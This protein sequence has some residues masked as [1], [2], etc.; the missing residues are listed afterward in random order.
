[1]EQLLKMGPVTLALRDFPIFTQYP[2]RDWKLDAFTVTEGTP[3]LVVCY[4]NAPIAATGEPVYR[5]HSV[6][7]HRQLYALPDGQL[8]WQQIYR[9]TLQLQMVVSRDRTVITVTADETQTC[10]MAVLE[11]LTFLVFYLFLQKQV[12]SFHGVLLEADGKGLVIAADSGVG[13][14]THARLWRDHKNALILN[15]DRSC[16]YS[17][18]GNWLGFGTPWCGTSGEYLNR[19]VPV[20]A[21]VVLER[22][23]VNQVTQL[24][25][26]QK[27]QTLLPHVL[28]PQF[29]RA[30]TGQA[31]T[32]L[33]RFLEDIPVLL[34]QCTPDV[35][36]VEVLQQYLE[37]QNDRT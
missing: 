31:W 20:C 17:C 22:S 2:F 29:D 35:Q 12:L 14:T 21:L 13:K 9:D 19:Q 8:L 27:L 24:H 33:E 26:A 36:A 30:L 15:G 1:M 6:Y 25:G 5:D 10:G 3:D 23:Y 18:Q 34:L 4:E 7:A 37:N 16:C 28:L 32:L 11:S